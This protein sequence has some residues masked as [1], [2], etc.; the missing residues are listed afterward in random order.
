[1]RFLLVNIYFKKQIHIILS[2]AELRVKSVIIMGRRAKQNLWD[3][4]I[5]EWEISEVAPRKVLSP[6]VLFSTLNILYGTELLNNF[7]GSHTVEIYN[8]IE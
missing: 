3:F 7:E 1:M 8:R 2:F 5:S 4:E 6:V